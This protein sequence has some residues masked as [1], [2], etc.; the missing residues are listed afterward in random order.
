MGNPFATHATIAES[1][2]ERVNLQKDDTTEY[3]EQI[4]GSLS[5]WIDKVP[6]RIKRHGIRR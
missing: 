4:N 1:A 2:E 5:S 6:T 3:Q